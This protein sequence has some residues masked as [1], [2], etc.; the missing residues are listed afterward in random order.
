MT[1]LDVTPEVLLAASAQVEALMARMTAANAVQAAASAAILP[2]GSD[3]PSI[4]VAA[5]LIGHGA[6]HELSATMGNEELFRSGIG[7]AESGVSYLLGETQGVT[8]YG[9]SAGL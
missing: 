7:V 5:A 1:F 8:A 2:P 9:A 3:A 4:K 6:A